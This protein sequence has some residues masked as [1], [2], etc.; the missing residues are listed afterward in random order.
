MNTL[1]EVWCLDSRWDRQCIDRGLH[2]SAEPR[3]L[4]EVLLVGTQSNLNLA[5]FVTSEIINE[6]HQRRIG[7]RTFYIGSTGVMSH[8]GTNA[9]LS[10]ATNA[11]GQMRFVRRQQRMHTHPDGLIGEE[12]PR[13]KVLYMVYQVIE[14]RV[15]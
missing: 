14:K 9:A 1:D 3:S 10:Q 4:H 6:T 2:I 5:M 11:L 8:G 13:V 15:P 7:L 12:D